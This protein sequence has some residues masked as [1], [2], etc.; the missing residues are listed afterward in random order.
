MNDLYKQFLNKISNKTNDDNE[1]VN[2]ILLN[3]EKKEEQFNLDIYEVKKDFLN[4]ACVIRKKEI[5]NPIDYSNIDDIKIES[6]IKYI[7]YIMID[8]GNNMIDNLMIKTFDDYDSAKKYYSELV[9]LLNNN[10]IY[11]LISIFDNYISQ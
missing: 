6:K 2:N 4:C 9:S 3:E 8:D 11:K 10:D 7:S 5:I 1:I